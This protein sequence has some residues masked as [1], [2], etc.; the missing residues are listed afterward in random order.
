MIRQPVV[1]GTFYPANPKTLRCNIDVYTSPRAA[2]LSAKACVVP[3]AG[4]VYSGPVAGAVYAALELPDLFVILAPNHYGRGAALALHP[5]TEWETPLGPARV[6]AELF[7]RILAGVP[8]MECDASAHDEHSLEVQIPFLQYLR[9][10]FA[11]VPIAIGTGDYATLVKT[12][13]ALAA[14]LKEE[15]RFVMIVASSDMNHYEDDRTTRRKD[16][17]AINAMLSLDM[18]SLY[19]TLKQERITMCGFGPAIVAITAARPMQGRLIKY[20]TSGDAS[21]ERD[22]VVGYAGLSFA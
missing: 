11:F 22:R 2:N 9:P 5:A 18:Q 1:A 15:S 16:R 20:A 13:Q 21:G 4:Y 8:G 19:E 7:S 17:A 10:D 6:D 14:V 12:G 3:H